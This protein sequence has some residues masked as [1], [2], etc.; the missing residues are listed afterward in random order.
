MDI[1]LPYK[2]IT[3]NKYYRVWRGRMVI[4]PEGR[5]FKGKVVKDL[6]PFPKMEGHI[7]LDITFNF[8]DRHIR[9]L[10]NL[11]KAL[12]DSL[13]GKIFDDDSEIYE[14]ATRKVICGEESIIIHCSKLT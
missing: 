1:K 4:S 7:K 8:K 13:K 11:T 3:Y 9:D 12:L 6:Y 14:L 5:E 10:D 2:A